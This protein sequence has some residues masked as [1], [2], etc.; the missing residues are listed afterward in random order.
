VSN[1]VYAP[2][3]AVLEGPQPAASP[4]PVFHA[5]SLPKFL[6]LA[7]GTLGFYMYYWIYKN[8]KL[9][10]QRT[11]EPV[12]PV[13]RTVFPIFFIYQLFVRINDAALE[14]NTRRFLA[15]PLATLWILVT[16]LWKL[17]DPYS[18]VAFLA[19]LILVPVQQAVND[20]NAVA[21]P[22]HDANTRFR[23]WNWVAVF[24][25]LPFFVLIVLV[26]LFP[27]P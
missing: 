19:A 4:S 15:G 6:V 13:W 17:P 1:N 23:G 26:T 21:A 5:V 12:S 14:R 10:V 20:L 27:E 16:I 2:P 22:G 11:G 3:A 8:W 7:Y 25:G 24:V 18:L 9:H